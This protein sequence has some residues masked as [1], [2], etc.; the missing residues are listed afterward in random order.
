MEHKKGVLIMKKILFKVV[1]FVLGIALLAPSVFADT[2]IPEG[3]LA[4]TTGDPNQEA[5]DA[6]FTELNELALEKHLLSTDMECK[7]STDSKQAAIRM[8]VINNYESELDAQLE[9]LGV[10]KIDPNN[11]ADIAQLEEIM[12]D[13]MM[14]G[15]TRSV[16]NPP[17]LSDFANVYSLHQ[18]NRTTTINGVT[19]NYSYIYVTDN[20]GYNGPLTVSKM[21]YGLLDYSP[22]V[23]SDLLDYSFSFGVSE[24]I[25][26]L[27]YGWVA[28]FTLG[29]LFTGLN[30]AYGGAIVT[31]GDEGN[32]FTTTM[33]SVTQ[34]MYCYVYYPQSGWMLCGVKAPNVSF[35]RSDVF[36]ANIN[37]R[38]ENETKEYPTSSYEDSTSPVNF[39][40]NYVT[41][42]GVWV[43]RY[44]CIEIETP[45][46][47]TLKFYPG[48]AEST[49]HLMK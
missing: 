44:G 22:K 25:G 27:P 7:S 31:A 13:T 5:I 8:D 46:I 4:D 9:Q 30:S 37:G 16:S 40:K 41:G 38:P 18:Y 32:I 34:M 10:H 1:C 17:D 43:R 29:G 24:G 47:G 2:S 42:N 6:L 19:Y 36:I 11:A 21:A 26:Q 28:N 45:E 33:M 12:M 3:S 48:F 35:T 23:L 20:K 15:S 14:A 39:V 49:I